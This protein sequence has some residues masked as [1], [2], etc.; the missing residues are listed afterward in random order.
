MDA[1]R[2]SP[3]RYLCVFLGLLALLGLI[4][5]LR[6]ST[7]PPRAPLM[8][9]ATAEIQASLPLLPASPERPAYSPPTPTP[10][11]QGH[12]EAQAFGTQTLPP[13]QEPAALLAFFEFYRREFGSFPTGNE[14]Q[15]FLHA[16][17]GQ[18]PT[19]LVIFPITHPR[20]GPNGTLLDAWG[21]PFL[22]HPISRHH[23]EVR[24]AGPDREPF[25]PDDIFAPLPRPQP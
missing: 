20:V 17:A 21:T 9:P 19:Q 16:L 4:R 24:S 18:N 6:P 5:L 8:A 12:P 1:P 23:L 22:F 10:D 7:A 2:M 13:E 11:T 15:H 25:T 14:N 3:I